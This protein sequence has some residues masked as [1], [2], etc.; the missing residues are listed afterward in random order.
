MTALPRH[1]PSP[2]SLSPSPTSTPPVPGAGTVTCSA[3]LGAR[4]WRRSSRSTGANNC[5][6][7]APVA[8]GAEGDAVGLMAVRDS[9]NAGGPALLFGPRAW[10]GFVS[11]LR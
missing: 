11:A 5:V 2:S 8:T 7:T 10:E 3:S 6:E 9:K 4:R 1:I